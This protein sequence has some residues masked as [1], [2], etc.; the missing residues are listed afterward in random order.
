M[1]RQVGTTIPRNRT[2]YY[3]NAI[4]V[5][6][7]WSCVIDFGIGADF[8]D[9][10]RK[11]GEVFYCPNGHGNYYNK[12]K[13]AE[14]VAR[15]KAEAELAAARSLAARES[16]RRRQAEGERAAARGE[17][18]QLRTRIGNGVCPCCNRTFAD[19]GQHIAGEHPDFR[20]DREEPNP[21]LTA[22]HLSHNQV[23]S[24]RFVG[25]AVDHGE[26]GSWRIFHHKA[27]VGA[28]IRRGVVTLKTIEDEGEQV[29]ILV[30]T[31][32]GLRLIAEIGSAR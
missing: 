9:R 31:A 24:V 19:L 32:T 29:E 8:M 4:H 21:T 30:P 10:R 17:V 28:L 7:C 26:E 23:E 27:T 25:Q 2:V 11:D 5:I 3:E 1:S 20:M 15:E 13:T 12:G 16:E 6:T 14:Q 18:T 22:E